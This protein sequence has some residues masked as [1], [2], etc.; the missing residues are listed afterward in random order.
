MKNYKFSDPEM[1]KKISL[2]QKM[3]MLD[4]MHGFLIKVM[5]KESKLI[6]ERLKKEGII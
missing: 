6:A 3:K 4:E 1:N 2:K 5:P